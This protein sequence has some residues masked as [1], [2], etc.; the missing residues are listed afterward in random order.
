MT[1]KQLEK[2]IR[3]DEEANGYGAVKRLADHLGVNRSTVKRWKRGDTPMRP[4]YQDAAE[5]YLSRAH[6]AL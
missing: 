1:P 4:L 5:R 6:N 3:K 2:L